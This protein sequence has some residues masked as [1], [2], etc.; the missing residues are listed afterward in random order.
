VTLGSKVWWLFLLL[1]VLPSGCSN[2]Q[3]TAAASV[4]APG[5]TQLCLC[6]PGSK[7]VQTCNANGRG[8]GKCAKC[9]TAAATALPR[10]KD[11]TPIKT[12]TR[13][14]QG[15]SKGTCA[16]LLEK[17]AGHTK[18]LNDVKNTL[19][20][21]ELTANDKRLE[22]ARKRKGAIELRT[23]RRRM[24]DRG[25]PSRHTRPQSF[26]T[27]AKKLESEAH[28]LEKT[29]CNPVQRWPYTVSASGV[30]TRSN[31]SGTVD[32]RVVRRR[33][34]RVRKQAITEVRS[35]KKC[36]ALL[37]D[38]KWKARLGFDMRRGLQGEVQIGR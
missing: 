36:A 35:L 24:M 10:G 29:Q 8:W 31:P 1:G 19:A 2:S 34:E 16:G 7:G 27:A 15:I 37:N 22:G 28:T 9:S 21:C 3:E 18:R 26:L 25:S 17:A 5:L 32:L 33:L 13:L 14:G 23:E 12:Q 6:G 30:V 4:C 11:K 38:L 20:E